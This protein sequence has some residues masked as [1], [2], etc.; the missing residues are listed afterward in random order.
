MMHYQVC[1]ECWGHRL[2]P[3][4]AT[5]EIIYRLHRSIGTPNVPLTAC[6]RCGGSGRV[7][8]SLRKWDHRFKQ[9]ID[10]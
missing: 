9:R 2:H 5:H 1:P 3:A 7:L 10:A 6:Q 8:A 4:P